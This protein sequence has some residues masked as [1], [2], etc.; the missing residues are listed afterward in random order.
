MT[1]DVERVMTAAAIAHQQTGVPITT[2]SEPGLRNGLAQQ[3]GL[4][5]RGV[6]ASRII[7]G[8]AGD[9]DDLDYLRAIMD[10]GSTV[11]FDRFGM[12]HMAS[13]EQ[14]IDTVVALVSRGYADRMI[15]SH[16]AAFFSHVTP[17]SWRAANAPRWEM[18]HLVRRILPTLR[19]RGVA[20]ADL[21]R[22]VVTNPARLL[23]P[24]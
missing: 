4:V 9:S 19:E 18:G 15:L 3:A 2:H 21:E 24:C 22:M 5:E 20:A 10:R 11:G 13:D 14:R 6:P 8:H 17:P 1:A 23:T 12:E 16:D 7:I